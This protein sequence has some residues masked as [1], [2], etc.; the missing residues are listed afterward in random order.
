M[1]LYLD[2]DTAAALLVQFLRRAGHD[3]QVPAGSGLAGEWDPVQLT[4][5]IR[6]NRILLTRNYEDFADLH[7]LIDVARGHHSGILVIRRDDD[8]RRNMS[9][10]DVVRALANLE[11]AGIPI[12]DQYIVLNPWQ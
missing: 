10:R 6:E 9:P 8:T 11:A 2:E 5:A 3:V 12:A 1:R 7:N 4:Y